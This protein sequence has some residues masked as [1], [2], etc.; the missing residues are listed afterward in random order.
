MDAEALRKSKEEC[1]ELAKQMAEMEKVYK[2]RLIEK[3]RAI[4]S[5]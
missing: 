2:E 4:K 3:D 1:L 5:K